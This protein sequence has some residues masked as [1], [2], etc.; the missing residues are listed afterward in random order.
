MC[1]TALIMYGLCVI[2]VW[3]M[4]GILSAD[5]HTSYTKI[6]EPNVYRVHQYQYLYND[7]R[8]KMEGNKQSKDLNGKTA[9]KINNKYFVDQGGK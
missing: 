4:F 1:C 8:F 2:M 6:K 7:H 9:V 3:G 5:V